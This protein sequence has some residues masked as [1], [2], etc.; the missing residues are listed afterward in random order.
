MKL[1]ILDRDGVINEDSDNY[2]R[3]TNDC[4]PIAGSIESIVK[5]NNAGFTVSV[6]TNQ[7]GLAR[8]YFS[9]PVLHQIHYKLQCLV[10][11]QGGE[12][13]TFF[14]C[15]HSPDDNCACRKPKAGIFQYIS[16]YYGLDLDHV[17]AIGDSERDLIASTQVDAKPI[18][19][20]TG[21]GNHTLKSI[22]N[23]H[24]PVYENLLEV[25]RQIIGKQK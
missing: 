3:S 14:F 13:D 16:N 8:N 11:E 25:S 12:I 7:S 20:L 4:I 6:A 17:P 5:F 10:A 15:P 2:I 18:L 23:N 24:Y 22:N 21:K 19:V 1:V 9:L